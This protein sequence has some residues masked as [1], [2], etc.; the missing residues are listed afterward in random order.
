M[1]TLYAYTYMQD[2]LVCVHV[3]FHMLSAR[4]FGNLFLRRP[5]DMAEPTSAERKAHE[6]NKTTF[7]RHFLLNAY[8]G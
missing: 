1:Y 3:L 4:Q 2:V 6:Q 8:D 5:P 7:V